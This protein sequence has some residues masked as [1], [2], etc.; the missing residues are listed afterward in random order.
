MTKALQFSKL[1]FGANVFGWTV[2]QAESFNLLDYALEHGISSIDTAD[3]YSVW[4]PGHQGGES[5]RIIGQWLKQTPSNRDKITLITKV[6]MKMSDTQQGLSKK[7]IKQAIEDSLKRLNTD[8]V[9]VYLSH[10]A[11]EHTPIEETLSAYAELL[12]EGKVLNIGASNYSG[13]QLLQALHTSAEQGLPK[14][15]VFEPEYSLVD[16]EQYETEYQPVCESHDLKVI[17][18]FSLASGFLTGKYRTLADVGK[19]SRKDMVLKY[20]NERGLNILTTLDQ[21]AAKYRAEVSEVALA[22]TMAHPSITAPIAS[23]TS[24]QQLASLVNATQ[25]TLEAEDIALLTQVS[26]Y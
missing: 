3:M 11:D 15:S 5:E 14:Y 18:Y 13:A 17:T 2:D 23:A 21:L 24:I 19:S 7:Y 10:C 8:Y 20:F 4:V 9:D 6:G 16:R 1:I 26:Q 25:L 12:Q 22:W